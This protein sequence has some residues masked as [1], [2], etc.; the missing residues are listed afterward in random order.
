MRVQEEN[1]EQKITLNSENEKWVPL[2]GYSGV[3]ISDS[4]KLRKCGQYIF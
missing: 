1:Q 2:Q 4:G 3:E